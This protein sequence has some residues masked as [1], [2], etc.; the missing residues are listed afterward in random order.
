MKKGWIIGII[1]VILIVALVIMFY[2]RPIEDLTQV[3]YDISKEERITFLSGWINTLE[4]CKG[5]SEFSSREEMIN[6]GYD[7]FCWDA[8]DVDDFN[9]NK[10]KELEGIKGVALST[11]ISPGSDSRCNLIWEYEYEY[12]GSRLFHRV[13]EIYNCEDKFY[14]NAYEYP[15]PLKRNIYMIN[16]TEDTLG[17]LKEKSI[18]E[19]YQEI[20]GAI[21]EGNDYG[22]SN[23]LSDYCFP[24]RTYEK[25]CYY[26]AS[27]NY[28]LFIGSN[29]SEFSREQRLNI[30][31]ELA[32][33]GSVADC[34]RRI[35][36]SEEC[37]NYANSNE[38]LTTLCNYKT[39][40]L[41][42]PNQAGIPSE[43][44]TYPLVRFSD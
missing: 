15:G 7:Q 35:N 36:E 28:V 23:N 3:E 43:V 9:L 16:P 25:N 41:P 2:P 21:Q 18:E 13:L 26:S 37:L 29:L 6:S 30:C 27:K 17:I 38:Y 44:K 1:G 33:S 20:L 34:L 12:V 24:W 11:S 14:I 32:H 31:Y 39:G 42:Y 5:Y 40:V 4:E 22:I 10:L 19:R 8:T